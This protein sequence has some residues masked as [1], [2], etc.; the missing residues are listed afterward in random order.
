MVLAQC[1][2]RRGEEREGEERDDRD[3]GMRKSNTPKVNFVKIMSVFGT[4]RECTFKISKGKESSATLCFHSIHHFSTSSLTDLIK[5][6][7]GNNA[8][9]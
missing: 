5:E 7:H 1:E 6:I 9:N 8:S 3:R 2:R 4:E